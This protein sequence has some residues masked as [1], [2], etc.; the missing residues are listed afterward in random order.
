MKVGESKNEW[1]ENMAACKK[2]DVL[3][4]NSKC[5]YYSV[6]DTHSKFIDTNSSFKN[7]PKKN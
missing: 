4:V 1:I 2:F 7:V 3:P 6:F 5:Y